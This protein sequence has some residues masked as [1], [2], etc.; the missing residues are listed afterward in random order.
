MR[1]V[2]GHNEMQ[3]HSWKLLLYKS[4]EATI[5]YISICG[6][7]LCHKTRQNFPYHNL[8]GFLIFFF[9]FRNEDRKLL[10]ELCK[11]NYLLVCKTHSCILKSWISATY[12]CQ[13]VSIGNT[14][15]DQPKHLLLIQNSFFIAP[16]KKEEIF[17]IPQKDANY[18]ALD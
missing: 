17:H 9:F 2:T 10:I 3:W 15:N 6:Q 12:N 5:I 8:W 14:F 7:N 4:R 1:I 18:I 11:A 13:V 16:A